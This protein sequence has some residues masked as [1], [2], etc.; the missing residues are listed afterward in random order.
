MVWKRVFPPTGGG[1]MRRWMR[2]QTA[3]IKNSFDSEHMVPGPITL[4]DFS[5]RNDAADADLISPKQEG[6]WR[7][8]DDEVIG[9]FSRATFKLIRTKNDLERYLLRKEEPVVVAPVVDNNKV[10]NNKDQ[11]NK[12]GFVPF[13][14]W[15]GTLDT[16][17]G[18]IASVERSGFCAIKSPTYPFGGAALRKFNAL[19]LKV[20]SDGR[21]YL[22][23]LHVDS[24]FPGDLYQAVL[25]IPPTIDGSDGSKTAF[26][27]VIFPFKQFQHTSQGRVRVMQRILD[28]G[29]SVETVGITLMDG[30]DGD[31]ELDL[32]SIRGVNYYNE[33]ILGEDD[34]LAPY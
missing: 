28:A 8:S 1:T 34:D 20:R 14:R 27:K 21:Q 11:T 15:K 32:A 17:I 13:I 25:A 2:L 29:A 33:E 26:S 23:N 31:F 4:F 10:D 5:D 30:Q 22:I 19:E 12:D 9:G 16:R 7:I 18:E 6:G 3:L 24:M